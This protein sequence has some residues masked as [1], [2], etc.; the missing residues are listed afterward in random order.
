[1]NQEQRDR[2]AGIAAKMRALAKARRAYSAG[3]DII[4][5]ARE[6]ETCIA[7]PV[8]VIETAKP[9]KKGGEL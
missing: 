8:D 6:I 2:L 5:Y 4:D 1:V 7:E 9:S 3:E